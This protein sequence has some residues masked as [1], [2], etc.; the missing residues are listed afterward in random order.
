MATRATRKLLQLSDEIS[1]VLPS[2]VRHASQDVS[3]IWT[4]SEGV[5]VPEPPQF[6]HL[7]SSVERPNC[8]WVE[9]LLYLYLRHDHVDTRLTTSSSHPVHPPPL[10]LLICRVFNGSHRLRAYQGT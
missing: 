8:S 6:E 9:Q 7:Q 4:I 5:F 3:G 2:P 1:N 10:M